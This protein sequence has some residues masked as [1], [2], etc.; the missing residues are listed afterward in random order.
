MRSHLFAGS[1]R[2]NCQV[3]RYHS[4]NRSVHYYHSASAGLYPVCLFD[5]KVGAAVVPV[6]WLEVAVVPAESILVVAVAGRFP[7]VAVVVE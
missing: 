3:L 5:R 7:A 2:T 4:L 1:C 6:D